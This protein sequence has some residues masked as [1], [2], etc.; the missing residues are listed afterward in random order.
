MEPLVVLLI[1][2]FGAVLWA[3]IAGCRRLE[4]R[5]HER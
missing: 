4:R 2:V 3:L 1:P 5:S